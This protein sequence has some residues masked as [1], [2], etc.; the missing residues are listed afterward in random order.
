M[1]RLAILS[2]GFIAA[3]AL[4]TPTMAQEATQEPGA[5]GFN[6]PD[7]R[8]L[9]GGYGVR[10]TPG[11]RYYYYRDAYGGPGYYGPGPVGFAPGVVIG[12]AD[13]FAYDGPVPETDWYSR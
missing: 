2:A 3:M 5:F 13:S 8:Y 1:T 6:Y 7:T 11:P 10:A 12:P 9:T 4:I